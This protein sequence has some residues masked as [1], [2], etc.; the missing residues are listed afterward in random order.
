MNKAI[1]RVSEVFLDFDHFRS[2]LLGW[3]VDVT[4]ISPGRLKLGWDQLAFD[5][6]LTLSHLE[7]NRRL[8]DQMSVA[9]DRITFVVCFARNI[10][11]GKEVQEGT[12]LIFGGGREYRSI[13]FEGFESFEISTSVDMLAD[14]GV[15]FNNIKLS[16]LSPE[17]CRIPLLK[18][19][20][21]MYR[22]L[23]AAV[24]QLADSQRDGDSQGNWSLAAREK[25]VN[26]TVSVL[27]RSQTVNVLPEPDTMNLSGWLLV[28]RAFEKIEKFGLK[29]VL[30]V[31]DLAKML[32]C[33]TRTLQVAFRTT[34]GIT[35]LQ[36]QL[37]RRLN[38]VR[39]ELQI[40]SHGQ[41]TVTELATAYEFYHFG[42]F[43]QYYYNLFGEL[44]SD[45]LKSF[46]VPSN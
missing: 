37:A 18:S 38:L 30:T 36:Y 41:A 17:N 19:E 26:L 43:A 13:L 14:W 34:L 8:A 22:G 32:G 11:C 21:A 9:H 40:T 27:Q 44:P 1:F 39:Q 35:P 2:V 24:S 16:N 31:S 15:E 29:K 45:T 6:G 46:K 7:T 4:Q 23:A 12:M 42:R 20:T 3:D 33:A 10:F 5:S 28:E 25:A